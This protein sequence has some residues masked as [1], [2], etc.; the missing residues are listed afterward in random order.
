MRVF[1]FYKYN[2]AD[3][4]SN[5]DTIVHLENMLIIQK[6]RHESFSFSISDITGK[7]I[8]DLIVEY[9]NLIKYRYYYDRMKKHIL[10]TMTPE[11]NQGKIY[12]SQGDWDSIVKI[13]S[14]TKRKFNINGG[15]ILQQIDWYGVGLKPAVLDRYSEVGK[16]TT[17]SCKGIVNNSII[18]E[19]SIE[20]NKKQNYIQIVVEATTEAA[21]RD[22]RDIVSKLE[23]Y[24][25][26]PFSYH[27]AYYFSSEQ[28]KKNIFFE[29]EAIM[30]LN[31][32]LADFSKYY[33]N[34]HKYYS[35]N[36]SSASIIDKKMI[37]R[38]FETTGFNMFTERKKG[39]RPGMNRLICLDK[40]NY[41]YEVIIDR[42]SDSPET[43]FVSF[44]IQGCNFAITSDL[45]AIEVN[46]K[47]DAEEKLYK[48]AKFVCYLKKKYEEY[49]SEHFGDT[50]KWYWQ[51]RKEH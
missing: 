11:W 51:D 46:N 32:E 8:S 33:G 6:L 42:T 22:T 47:V 31:E 30:L 40:H 38:A 27:R 19:K 20:D 26:S 36:E 16:A 37:S 15:L 24:I 18:I 23:P 3:I 10:T 49:L 35:P 13:F 7:E 34:R 1:D 17:F 14:P 41:V 21:P 25:G 48:F 29:D 4:V 12:A 9:P 43:F 45:K 5:R 39:D 50:P 44:S 28:T 2:I